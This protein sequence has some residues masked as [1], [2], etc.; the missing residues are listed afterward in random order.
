MTQHFVKSKKVICKMEIRKLKKEK[1]I[2]F[3]FKKQKKPS[4][5]ENECVPEHHLLY[6]KAKE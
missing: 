2:F 3:P 4:K 1:I 5:S 6:A